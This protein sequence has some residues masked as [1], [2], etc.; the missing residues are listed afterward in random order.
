VRFRKQRAYAIVY[1][2]N[3]LLRPFKYLRVSFPDYWTV[4]QNFGQDKVWSF[5]SLIKRYEDSF[6]CHIMHLKRT[7]LL[8]MFTVVIVSLPSTASLRS[9]VEVANAQ[10][11][12][13]DTGVVMPLTP[14]N[15]LPAIPLHGYKEPSTV[16]SEWEPL[17]R[18]DGIP[19]CTVSFHN[20]ELL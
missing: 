6:C 17:L 2:E 4:P 10:T 1:T 20:A 8:I 13:C 18:H 11:S 9:L 16:W 7:L 19:F 5:E 3:T 14:S 15:A 12:S